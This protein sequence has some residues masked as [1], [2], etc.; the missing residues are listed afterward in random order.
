MTGSDT[1]L[2][3]VMVMNRIK[4]MLH[5][6]Y[7]SIHNC[8]CFV[9]MLLEFYVAFS[10]ENTIINILNFQSVYSLFYDKAMCNVS[11]DKFDL[12]M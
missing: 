2:E 6:N 4:F 12:F 1:Y 7:F 3:S 10:I 11:P 9:S 5:F 8:L